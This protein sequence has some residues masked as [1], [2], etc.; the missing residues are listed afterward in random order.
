[1][2]ENKEE[3][4]IKNIEIK[5]FKCFED[6]KAEGFGRVNLIGGK[7]NVGKTA[8]M[9]ACYINNSKKNLNH[10]IRI[11]YVSD[12]LLDLWSEIGKKFINNFIKEEIEN[13]DNNQIKTNVDDLKVNIVFKSSNKASKS[14]YDNLYSL[15]ID[16]ELEDKVDHYLQEFD[17]SIEKFRIK[18]SKPYCQKNGEFYSLNEFG[19]GLGKFLYFIMFFLVNEK[20]IVLIDELENGIHYT[21]LD[22][23]WKIILSISKQ[24]NVQVFATTHSKEC[25]ESYARVA[26]KLE[27]EEIGFIELGRN[28]KN[29]L[30]S[31]VMDSEM[32]QRFVK[33]G[34]EV[35]GW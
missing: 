25:I 8:F 14:E 35:R 32:F 10:M 12:I 4:F 33:L 1:M 6:F 2:E 23:L 29:K 31:V 19:D 24:Q 18:K 20:S 3:H 28:K 9:E 22:K 11:R 30:D 17:S 27:D 5:N 16:N 15:I 13:Y 21:N 34:N 7:N 26:K